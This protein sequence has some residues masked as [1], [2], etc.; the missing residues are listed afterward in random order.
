MA[1]VAYASDTARRFVA[2]LAS[3][4]TTAALVFGSHFMPA[5]AAL[6]EAAALAG[7][8]VASGLVVSDRFLPAALRQ[9]V[10]DAY[11]DSVDL[12]R[13]F[14]RRGRLLYAVT[15]RFALSTSDAMLEMCQS[16]VREHEDVRITSHVNEHHDEMHQVRSQFPWARDY[17]AVYERYGLAGS[18]SVLAHNVH[19]TAGEIQRLSAT[20][21]SIAHCPCSNASLGGGIFPLRAHL[22]AGVHVALGTDV[23]AGTG[24]GVMKEALHAYLLQR[25][26]S[27]GA[28]LD[29]ARMLY[30]STLAGAEALGLADVAG[31]FCSGKSA[32]FV[33]LKPAADSVLDL[34]LRHASNGE[35]ALAALFTLG[36]AGIVR[37]TR[38]A[39]DV[40]YRQ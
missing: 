11:R 38:V 13:R 33:H 10:S 37:E 31:S 35:D 36:D 21:T 24:F 32:D 16:L 6:F 40:V 25:V 34:V 8:R 1:D 26:A 22:D 29:A 3:H 5:T 18:R 23:G 4:G 2:A 30:L 17:F 14:H 12:I 39:G 20:R 27:N 28:A 19:P 7:V 15:P 9:S